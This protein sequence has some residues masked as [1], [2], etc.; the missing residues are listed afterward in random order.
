MIA[1]LAKLPLKLRPTIPALWTGPTRAHLYKRFRSNFV[2][3]H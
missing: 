1:P 3:S 2:G